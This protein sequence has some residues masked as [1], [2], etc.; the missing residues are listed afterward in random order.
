MS[1]KIRSVAICAA[2]LLLCSIGQAQLWSI[3][4]NNSSQNDDD[5]G[6]CI[7]FDRWGNTFVAGKSWRGSAARYAF[8]VDSYDSSGNRR[9][10][11]PVV[12]DGPVD[13][14]ISQLP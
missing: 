7:A 4:Y 11:F 1:R 8:L 14:T 5:Q 6:Q 10:G 3:R 12:Y 13:G 2:A 9:T